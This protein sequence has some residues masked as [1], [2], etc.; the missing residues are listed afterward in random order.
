MSETVDRTDWLRTTCAERWQRVEDLHL[1]DANIWLGKPGRAFPLAEEV[2]V[3]GLPQVM[4][5]YHIAGNLGQVERLGDRNRDMDTGWGR[6]EPL[7]TFGMR[8]P[9]PAQ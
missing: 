1:F 8:A 7:A 3:G 5:D 6:E 4:A 2:P 9:T